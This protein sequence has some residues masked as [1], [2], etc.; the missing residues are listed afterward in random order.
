MFNFEEIEVV[1]DLALE[2]RN[3][4]RHRNG[5][6]WT[7]SCIVC[8]DSSKNLRKARFGVA[9][10]DNVLVCHCFNCGYSNTFSSYIKEYHP[11]NYEKLL[12]IK[13]DESAPTM[14]DLNHL[15]NLAEDITVSLF[16]I[17]KF[18]NRKEWLDYLV[19]KKIK[20]TK[21]SIRKLFETHGRYWSNR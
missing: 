18:Q 12:K 6:S 1:N 5:K 13:F 7:W 2:V 10:K 21:K 14:Y 8:G 20:L 3:F 17:N 9:L 11:H 16:F 4:K 15:V 19:S